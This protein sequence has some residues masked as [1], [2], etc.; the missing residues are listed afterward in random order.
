M[1]IGLDSSSIIIKQ[2]NFDNTDIE[3]SDQSTIFVD[4]I[5]VI[6]YNH[7]MNLVYFAERTSCARSIL[8]IDS[9]K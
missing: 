6:D 7:N 5:S 3:N 8:I 1:K 4:S 2:D 9:H